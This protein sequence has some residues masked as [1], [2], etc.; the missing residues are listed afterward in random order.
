[1]IRPYVLVCV[2]AVVLPL[3]ACD[4]QAAGPTFAMDRSF[5]GQ[6]VPQSKTLGAARWTA[7]DGEIVAQAAKGA[8]GWLVLPVELGNLAGYFEF[9]CDKDCAAGVLIRA[10]PTPS[11]GLHGVLVSAAPVGG[12]A[13]D[14]ELDAHGREISR[15]PLKAGNSDGGLPNAFG[16]ISQET[17]AA[18]K[19]ILSAPNV[20]VPGISKATGEYLRHDWNSVNVIAYND[21]LKPS[22][23]GAPGS[24]YLP[25][26][27]VPDSAGGYGAVA[28]YAGGNGTVRFRNVE[29]KDLNVRHT[30]AEVQSKNFVK[31]QLDAM[32]YS[33]GPAVGDF[34]K[35]G[36]RD[37][38]AGPFFWEGPTFEK[39]HEIYTPVQYNPGSDYPQKSFINLV[40]DFNKDGWDDVLVISGSAGYSTVTLYLN[41][42]GESRHWD[43]C[44][45]LKPIGNE[46]TLFEDI[47]GDGRPELIHAAKNA[48]AYSTWDDKNPCSWTTTL[49]SEPGPWGSYIGHGI[50]VG[51]VNGDGRKDMVSAYGWFEQPAEKSAALWKFHPQAFGRRGETQGGAGG[52][53]LGVYDVNGDGLADIV[54]PLEGHGFGLA[55]YEQKRGSDGSITFVQH[56]IMDGFLAKNAGDVMFTEPH[57]SA[58]A[59]IDGDGIPDLITGKRYMSH[60]A[61]YGDPDPF[62]APVLY[63]YHTVRNPSAPGGAEFVPELINNRSGVGSHLTVTD[64]DGDGKPDIVT[65]G[66]FGTFLF[67]NQTGGS[68]KR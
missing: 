46:E 38:V 11:G 50:G 7:K 37:I 40:Y 20:E 22:L 68:V 3:M 32:Y 43:S 24:Q 13:F 49:V 57:A 44:V 63:V 42:K 35:D 34:N 8:G 28:L 26:S 12:G 6:D 16:N 51:D 64:V 1:M 19:T 61:N 29:V 55:W 58:F 5:G 54:T 9:R 66:A 21:A 65:S 23:N 14:L 33:W 2:A 67:L 60:L 53:Q 31:K 45:V 25:D 47:D 41:P 30:P 52:A 4:A 56:M 59:D 39:S 48:L 62:G 10:V 17:L 27:L 36:K 15:T 18:L